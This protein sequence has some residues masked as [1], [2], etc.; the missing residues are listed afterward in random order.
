ML[1]PH[2]LIRMKRW[3]QHPPPLWKVCL[4]LA[5]IAVSLVVYTLETSG[6]L[7]GWMTADQIGRRPVLPKF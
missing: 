5:V 1:G 4:V 7:P 3:T 2:W 6:L